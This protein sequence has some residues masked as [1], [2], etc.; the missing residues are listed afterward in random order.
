MD[1]F[2]E[3]ICYNYSAMYIR[4][5]KQKNKDGSIRQYVQICRTYRVGNKVRQETLCNLGRLENLTEDGSIDTMIDGL[6][7]DLKSL[8]SR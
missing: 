5:N 4:I 6:A 8:K 2:G 3:F 1:G 7:K